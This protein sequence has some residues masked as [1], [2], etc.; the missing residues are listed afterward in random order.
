MEK[1]CIVKR[2]QQYSHLQDK[3]SLQDK[4]TLPVKFDDLKGR[5]KT[6]ES[7][8]FFEQKTV[9]E[10][11]NDSDSVVSITMTEEQTKMLQTSEYI[12]DLL[13]GTIKDHSFDIER[14]TYGRFMLNFRIKEAPLLKML[15]SAQVCEMLQIGRSLLMRL[16][17]EEKIKSYKIGR[18][19]RF[20]W[21]DILTYLL[22][23]EE[24]AQWNRTE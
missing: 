4:K 9:E 21:E 3:Q 16:I 15:S 22:S 8:L 24:L 6:E 20:L 2:R 12:K 11:N 7:K 10:F 13:N 19:R 17:H 1:I 14:D 23:N 5:I 18:L